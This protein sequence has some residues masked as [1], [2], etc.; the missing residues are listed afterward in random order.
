MVMN[1]FKSDGERVYILWDK[2]ARERDA[3]GLISLY[4]SDAVL[5]SPLVCAVLD[6]ESGVL[7]GHAQ[8]RHFFEEGGRRRPNQLVRWHREPGRFCFDGRTLIWEYPR[9]A[10]DGNQIEILEVMDFAGGLIA[11]HRIYWGWFGI[12][13]LVSSAVAKAQAG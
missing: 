2:Y 11:H 9:M 10:P 4:A 5:E 12:K 3:A 6:T 8:L 7:N 13:Q 1:E